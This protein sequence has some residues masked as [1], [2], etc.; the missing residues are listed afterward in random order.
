MTVYVDDMRSKYRRLILSHMMAD[1]NDELYAMAQTIGIQL[2]HHQGDHFDICQV[3]RALAI[4]SG[5]VEV[6][7]RQLA[8]MRTRRRETGVLGDPHDALEWLR[9]FRSAR[10]GSKCCAP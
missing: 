4:K 5:A 6:T 9:L 7:Q 2:K 3:K 10:K 1:S 8:A